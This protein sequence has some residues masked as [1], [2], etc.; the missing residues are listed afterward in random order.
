MVP[1]ENIE[2]REFVLTVANK[3][4][5]LGNVIF[6]FLLLIKYWKNS[7]GTHATVF[8]MGI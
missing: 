4:M 8:W 6:S 2:V 5:L 3:T 7:R 1:N